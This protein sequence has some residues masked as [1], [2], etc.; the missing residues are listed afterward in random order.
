M[1][2]AA[3]KLKAPF[4]CPTL[5][6]PVTFRGKPMVGYEV[7][8]CGMIWS[9]LTGKY[10]RAYL[11]ADGYRAVAL[12]NDGRT[13]RATVHAIVAE[14][15]I[16]P[17]PHESDVC[18]NDGSRTNNHAKNLRYASRSENLRDRE[19]HGTAQRGQR[20]PS[21][22]LTDAQANEIRGLRSRGAPLKQIAAMFG[23]RESTVSRIANGSRR[24]L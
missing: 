23:V 14:A 13:T 22:K 12:R 24:A 11:S 3:E 4:P 7:T 9:R 8:E 21:A 19:Q 5:A 20:N 10:L 15:W 17:R 1:T 16:G 18:H 6:R 2:V